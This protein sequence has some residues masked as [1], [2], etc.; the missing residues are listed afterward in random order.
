M[1]SSTSSCDVIIIGGGPGGATAA[2]VLARAGLKT[3]VL[4]KAV[5]PRFHIGESILPQN[6]PL[7]QELGLEAAL[8]RLPHLTKYGAEFAMGDDPASAIE[9][10]FDQ[11]LIPGSVTFN[12]ERARFDE[13]LL[14]EAWSAGADVRQNTA[15]EKI[16]RLND[17]DVA[18]VAGGQEITGKYIL[19]ASGHGTVVARHLGIRKNFEDE[20]LK[21]VAYFAQFDNVQR[22]PGTATGHP[23]IIM[24]KEGWFWI[25]GLNETVTSVGFV[26]QPNFARSLDVPANRILAWAIARC[27]VVRHRMRNASGP[28]TNQVLADFSYRCRPAAGPGYFLVGDAAAFLDPIFS[29]GVTLAMKGGNQAALRTIDI[30]AGTLAPAKARRQYLRYINGSTSI[31]WRLIRGYYHHSFRE[32]F[33]NGV[34]PL[35]I[36]R[37]VIAVLAGNVFPKPPW[38]LRW[39]LR[40]FGLCVQLN[41]V[42]PMVPRRKEFS[43]LSQSPGETPAA[44]AVRAGAVGD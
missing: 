44:V 37:A 13:M 18:V 4:E 24:C 27:P 9:F 30:L 33:L 40:V 3:I 6:F 39:R 16:V 21:K 29:T 23:T 2:L 28:E 20:N 11:G 43:L 17:G 25:I 26:T 14:N 12:I 36:H 10:T 34:G 5:F 42:I 22:L 19:D 35:Q 32:L 31:F 15:V 8:K 38:C 1:P 41:K 7:I